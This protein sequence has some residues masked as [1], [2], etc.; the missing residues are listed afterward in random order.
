MTEG[1][2]NPHTKVDPQWVQLPEEY[3]AR[4]QKFNVTVKSRSEP[5]EQSNGLVVFAMRYYVLKSDWH[6]FK[7]HARVFAEEC[8]RETAMAYSRNPRMRPEANGESID[9]ISMRLFE[10]CNGN[11]NVV[12]IVF[13]HAMKIVR[14]APVNGR[15]WESLLFTLIEAMTTKPHEFFGD[16]RF[17]DA[18]QR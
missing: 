7:L 8:D 15:T 10:L 12:D 14:E 6:P 18:T 17:E 3:A 2:W 9:E 11:H 4:Y 5:L 1:I 16:A 13:P